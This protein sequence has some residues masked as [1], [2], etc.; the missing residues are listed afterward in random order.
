M[1]RSPLSFDWLLL[2]AGSIAGDRR[3]CGSIPHIMR[4]EIDLGSSRLSMGG[5]R[6]SGKPSRHLGE[7]C[8]P[9]GVADVQ[10][11]PG[12]CANSGSVRLEIGRLL[13]L[14]RRTIYIPTY[15]KIYFGGKHD[16][17]CRN[18]EAQ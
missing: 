15:R 4:I 18:A 5:W 7:L 12:P 10:M 8:R 17:A 9:P 11:L 6:A 2:L 14:S 3:S 1:L 16:C 13:A